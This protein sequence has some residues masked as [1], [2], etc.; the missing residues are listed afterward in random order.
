[1]NRDEIRTEL[2]K[3]CRIVTDNQ[4]SVIEYLLKRPGSSNQTLA[5]RL[6]LTFKTVESVTRRLREKELITDNHHVL[7]EVTQSTQVTPIKLP[8]NILDKQLPD[9]K[10]YKYVH[11]AA[12]LANYEMDEVPTEKYFKGV[13]KAKVLESFKYQ[14]DNDSTTINR[15]MFGMQNDLA[16]FAIYVNDLEAFKDMQGTITLPESE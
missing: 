1:M 13:T 9:S 11:V 4:I 3:H 8:K 2:N 16:L 10:W 15:T 7:L 14:I 6:G 12:A 5:K